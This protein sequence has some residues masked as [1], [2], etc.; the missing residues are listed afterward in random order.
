MTWWC[1]VCCLIAGAQ[2]ITVRDSVTNQPLELVALVSENPMAFTT[3]NARGEADISAFRDAAEIQVRML[4]YKT[5]VKSYADLQGSS[6]VFLIPTGVSLDHVVISAVKWGQPAQEVPNKITSITEKS[7]ALQMPQTQADLLGASGEVYIQ[8]SQQGGGSPMIRG[9]ATNRVLYTVD[10]VRMNTAIFRFGNLQN[11]I[12]LDPFATESTEVLFGPGCVIYGSDA[13]GGVMNFQTL[14]PQFS[15]SNKTLVTGKA[16]TRYSSVN[17]EFTGHFDVN[18]G[19][20]KWSL[21]TSLS[22]NDYNDLRMGRHGPDEYL[23]PF[24]VQRQDSVD[25]VVTNDDPLV[26]KPSGY[27]QINLM[28]KLRFKPN[29]KWD[30]QYAFHYSATTDYPRYDRLIRMRNGL[31]RS[32]EWYY[33]PQVWMMNNLTVTNS[34]NNVVYDQLTIRLAHQRFEESRN[35]RDFND[36]ELRSRAEEVNAWSANLDF[37]KSLGAKHKLYY[38]L[39]VVVDDVN[40]TGTDKDISTGDVVDGPSRYPQST[41]SSY[42]AYVMWHW[43]IMDKLM[44]QAGARYNYY[45]LDAEFDT[46]FYPFPFTTADINDG[47]ITGSLGLAYKPTDKWALSLNFSTGFR[48]PNV[49]DAGKVFDS[50]PGSVVIPNPDLSSEYVYNVEASVAKVFGDDVKLDV[51]G[52]YTFLND[53]LIRDNFTLNGEDSIIYDG[54]LSQVQAI[55]N[56]ANAFVYGVQAGIEVKLP[57]GF[58]IASRINYQKGEQEL[59]DGTTSP[60]PHVAP[61]FG[62]TDLTYTRDKLQLDWYLIYNG[63]VDPENIPNDGEA[64]FLTNN[65]GELY[66]PRWY[67]MNFKA[68]YQI[69]DNFGVSAGVENITDQRYRPYRSGIVAGGRNFSVA[70]RANF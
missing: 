2:V 27:S 11:V 56:G 65:D 45:S 68:L 52:Y 42:A 46:T 12:S 63:K 43:R 39:E 19:W 13:I 44:L 70:L 53:I 22:F 61:L 47:A 18:V 48:S 8:K 4:G 20:K 58:G 40:S 34:S 24:Y 41:W 54:E 14:T 1:L 35:D 28:Q 55:Q 21:L 17:N 64:P 3:T 59:E 62:R 57:Q 5:Q 33:G 60:L 51:T 67:T 30:F 50:A 37:N 23:T 7:A 10:G 36:T 69:T 9:F 38:G 16:V 15:F 32:A 29:K 66:C 6:G 25:V 49:D 26:Q 31:P